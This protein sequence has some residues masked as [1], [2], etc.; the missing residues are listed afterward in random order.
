MFLPAWA[1]MGLRETK[2]RGNAI[3]SHGEGGTLAAADKRGYS[4]AT[5]GEEGGRNHEHK[6]PFL[7]QE[8]EEEGGGCTDSDT[9]AQL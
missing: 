9:M 7:H 8:E 1:A 5:P 4:P 6:V 3:R 2:Q